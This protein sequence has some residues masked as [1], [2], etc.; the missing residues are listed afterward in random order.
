MDISA[1][2]AKRDVSKT[3]EP[4]PAVAAKSKAP[5]R[6][7][8]QKH[9]AS[10]LHYDFRLEMEGVLRSWAVPRGL[11]P[12]AGE[13]RLAMAVEDH[14]LAY[15]RFEGII[16][17]GNYGAGTVMLWDEGT[18][19]VEGG[20]PAE[21]W[22]RGKLHLRLSGKKLRGAWALVRSGDEKRWLIIRRGEDMLPVSHEEND[23]SVLTGRTMV[24]IAS[25]AVTQRENEQ[26]AGAPPAVDPDVLHA[27]PEAVPSFVA[28]M[29]LEA[30]RQ[31]PRGEEWLYEAKFDGLRALL[32]KRGRKARLISRN[33]KD[34][35][36]KYRVL[37]EAAAELHCDSAVLDGEI[38]LLDAASRPSFQGLQHYSEQ[39]DGARLRYFAFDLLNF[40]GRSCLR[41]PLEQ[42]RA[43]L[44][45]ILAGEPIV[46][47][48]ELKASADVVVK[49][50]REAGLEGVV[51]KKRG[52]PYDPE[53][54]GGTWVKLKL[55]AG[56]ELVIGGYTKGAPFDAVLVGYYDRSRLLFAGKV[57]AGFDKQSRSDLARLLRAARVER[58]PFANLPESKGGRRGEGLTRDE[59]KFCTWVEPKIVAQI[60]FAEWTR[61]GHLR[62]ASYVGL[63]PD[64]DPRDVRREARAEAA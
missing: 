11:S 3:S 2:G 58:C 30:V 57:R 26:A 32:L 1:Y 61:A 23:R 5:S 13:R 24:E 27:L 33:E 19:V 6:F 47:S 51:A 43:Y 59:M 7:V 64:K 44:Q 12:V 22:R 46:F 49:A 31:L 4:A 53:T 62:H 28:P 52:S 42:R 60:A 9:Q 20:D 35:G 50:V 45:R 8:V 10:H 41:L 55:S 21:G 17:P 15:A 37:R 56:Q 16:P 40:D 29:K 36:R 38:V 34:L 25:Q 54:R 18:Y 14:P 39:R 63:R 48:E